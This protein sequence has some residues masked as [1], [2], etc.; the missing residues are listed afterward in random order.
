MKVLQCM[1]LITLLFFSSARAGD[2]Y[3]SH[4]YFGIGYTHI[5]AELYGYSVTNGFLGAILGYRLN[6]YLAIDLRAYGNI[7]D[8]TINDVDISAEYSF[9]AL[10]KGVIPA[11]DFI[12]FYLM[13]GMASSK[14][15][16]EGDFLSM[17]ETDE[18]LQYGAGVS[19]N[20]GEA[21]ETQ[22]EWIQLYDEDFLDAYGINLNIVYNFF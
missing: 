1:I 4:P 11:N 6:K 17:T 22:I 7:V 5:D 18:N 3:S 2:R 21:V 19:I 15:K 12:D 16:I 13:V 9:S 10:A 20:K 14:L 8:D